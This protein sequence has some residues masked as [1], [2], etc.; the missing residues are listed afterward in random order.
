L[1]STFNLGTHDI[2]D[3]A[4]STSHTGIVRVTGQIIAGST[5]KGIVA[6][7]YSVSNTCYR[8]VSHN[9]TQPG[10]YSMDT[11]LPDGLYQVAIFVVEENRHPFTRAAATP[12]FVSIYGN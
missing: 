9:N 12:K 2:Y 1:L 11:D 6:I 10:V 5:S 3:I 4:V 7:I 8:Y